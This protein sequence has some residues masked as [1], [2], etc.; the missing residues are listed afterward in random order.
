MYAL[1]IGENVFIF[2]MTAHYGIHPIIDINLEGYQVIKNYKEV[3]KHYEKNYL[4]SIY[5]IEQYCDFLFRICV[6]YIKDLFL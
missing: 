5:K 6:I 2:D 1:I 3:L 4:D